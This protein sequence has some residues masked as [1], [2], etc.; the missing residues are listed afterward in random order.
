MYDF[1]IEGPF[2]QGKYGTSVLYTC[3]MELRMSHYRQ[4]KPPTDGSGN[5]K[6]S[7][8]VKVSLGDLD[9]IV[10]NDL[11][12]KFLLTKLKSDFKL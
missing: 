7:K 6:L 8:N 9:H 12:T 3:I 1:E 5:E 11:I 10:T 2:F 4:V